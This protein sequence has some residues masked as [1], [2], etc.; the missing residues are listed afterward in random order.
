LNTPSS[1]IRDPSSSLEEI[2]RC[3][4]L[5]GTDADEWMQIQANLRLTPTQRI[6]NQSR[7]ATAIEILR[8]AVQK[9]N[10]KH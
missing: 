1:P 5:H 2:I 10:N 6:E 7:A 3:D 4:A 9:A 8:I